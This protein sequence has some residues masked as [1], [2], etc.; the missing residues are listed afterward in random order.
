[1]GADGVYELRELDVSYN[2]NFVGENS[3]LR[4]ENSYFWNISI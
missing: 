1:M 2:P 4:P 3:G